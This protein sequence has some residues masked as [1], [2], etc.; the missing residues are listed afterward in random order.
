MDEVHYCIIFAVTAPF[1]ILC[2]WAL[3]NVSMS[4]QPFVQHRGRKLTSIQ[5]LKLLL[6]FDN[7]YLI[8]CTANLSSQT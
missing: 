6:I 3:G 4:I 7:F 2:N 5:C 8:L 1:N